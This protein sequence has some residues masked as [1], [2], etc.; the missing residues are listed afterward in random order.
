MKA[1]RWIIALMFLLLTTACVLEKEPPAPEESCNFQQDAYLQRI[2]W[3]GQT[4][5]IYADASLSPRHIEALQT[6][7]A[8][9]N[10][11][12]VNALGRKEIFAYAGVMPQITGAAKDGRNVVTIP[13]VWPGKSV[14]NAH[15]IVTAKG[16]SVIDADIELNGN[17]RFSAQADVVQSNE[18]DLEALLIH[19]L[20]HALGLKDLDEAEHTIMY[21]YL[22]A[23]ASDRRSIGPMDV[24]A[25]RCEY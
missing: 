1:L 17:K 21:G 25:L 20:G 15:T 14:E 19:E 23:G 22:W 18:I 10:D 7:I 6:A 8:V 12:F 5:T 16:D 11:T 13:E 24:D 4:M 2:H 9:W 3:Y